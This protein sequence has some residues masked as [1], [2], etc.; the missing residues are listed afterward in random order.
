MSGERRRKIALGISTLA[1]AAAPAVASANDIFLP[2]VL[3]GYVRFNPTEIPAT[4][5]PTVPWNPTETPVTREPTFTPNSSQ[6]ASTPRP[7]GGFNPTETP[8]GPRISPTPTE[9]PTIETPNAIPE[10]KRD[11]QTCEQF[12]GDGK[13]HVIDVWNDRGLNLGST[14]IS[15][16]AERDFDGIINDQGADWPYT[17]DSNWSGVTAD[18]ARHVRERQDE[19]N[20]AG[21]GKTIRA[22]SMDE[23][24]SLGAVLRPGQACPQPTRQAPVSRRVRDYHYIRYQAR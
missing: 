13:L 16:I 21:N 19:F 15:V 17:P 11:L 9:A 23:A 12:T 2:T 7:T 1:T 14:E 3:K 18:Q 24:L 4:R 6:T 22:V 5:R 20:A 8:M 10:D